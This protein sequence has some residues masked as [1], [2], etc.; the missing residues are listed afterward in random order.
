MV[1]A[2]D[3]WADDRIG[4]DLEAG[5]TSRERAAMKAAV[6]TGRR[7]KHESMQEPT[8]EDDSRIASRNKR[9]NRGINIWSNYLDPDGLY[10]C[11]QGPRLY[12]G[13]AKTHQ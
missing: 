13:R 1:A 4:A 2:A 6:E 8:K 3:L 9:S 12:F 7:A 11:I 10:E 5:L